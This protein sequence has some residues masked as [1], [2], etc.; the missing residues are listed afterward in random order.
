L[1]NGPLYVKVQMPRVKPK[2]K[3]Y[4]TLTMGEN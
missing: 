1:S 3:S 4:G 2:D